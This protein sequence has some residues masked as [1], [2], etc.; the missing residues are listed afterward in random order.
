M[1]KEVI[2]GPIEARVI[3]IYDGDTVTVRAKVWLGQEVE[4]KVRLNG[5]DTPEMRGKCPEEKVLAQQARAFTEA[6]INESA[7]ATVL[8]RDAQYGKYAGRVL[9]RLE[10]ANG[11]DLTTALIKANLG[12]E[13]HGGKRDGWC[14]EDEGF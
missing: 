14:D 2:K 4:I 3:D 10:T 7:T 1:A 13:Y 9:G 5:I 8:L 11:E 12:R 6:R